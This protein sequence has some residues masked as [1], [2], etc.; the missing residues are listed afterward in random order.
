[1]AA[2]SP[3]PASAKPASVLA[4]GDDAVALELAML[5]VR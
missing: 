5:K 2:P 1:V 4:G 3:S